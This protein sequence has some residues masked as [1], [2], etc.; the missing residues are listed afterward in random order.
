MDFFQKKFLIFF[1]KI[2]KFS[3][4][5]KGSNFAVECD[6]ISKVSQ[7]LQNLGFLM[8]KNDGFL[9]KDIDVFEKS[10]N[11]ANLL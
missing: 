7:R 11:V 9:E 6:W 10:L 4:N 1:E 5:A 3:K 8:G 2:I